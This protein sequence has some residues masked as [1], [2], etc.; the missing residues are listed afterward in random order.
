MGTD[1]LS[2]NAPSHLH[3]AMLHLGILL[4]GQVSMALLS[5]YMARPLVTARESVKTQT[6]GFAPLL[7]SSITVRKTARNSARWV[8]LFLPSLI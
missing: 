5:E 3:R 4:I 7:N 6:Q 1:L 2:F 8:D